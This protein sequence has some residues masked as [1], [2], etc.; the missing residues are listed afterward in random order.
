MNSRLLAAATTAA[1]AVMGWS[2]SAQAVFIDFESLTATTLLGG[3]PPAAA[4]LTTNLAA[5]GI[6]FGK[7]GVS[8]GVAVINNNDN[9]FSSPNAISGLDASGDLLQNAAGDTYWSFVTA[10]L[11]QAVT[12]LLTFK[13]GDIGGDI[14]SWTISAF[15][16]GDNLLDT[17]MLSGAAHQTYTLAMAGIHRIEILNTTGTTAGYMVDDIEFNTV[18]A[19]AVPEPGALAL[20]GLG[21]AGLG[22]VRRRRVG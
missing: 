20:F 11:G 3:T 5:Q 12:D 16:T 7:A 19:A 15:G 4:V 13:I 6:S 1:L 10:G 17:Q 9:A 18:V 8:A 21:L 2:Q 14:D 22:F